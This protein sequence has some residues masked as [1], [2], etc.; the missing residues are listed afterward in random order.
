MKFG[1]WTY[2]GFQVSVDSLVVHLLGLVLVV[3]V[4]LVCFIIIISYI[5]IV[6]C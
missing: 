3:V 6:I 4:V 5:N 1:S 2:D